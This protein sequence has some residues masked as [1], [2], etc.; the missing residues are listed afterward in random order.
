MHIHL[1]HQDNFKGEA[2]C[3]LLEGEGY[4][5]SFYQNKVIDS[6]SE[7]P[8]KSSPLLML[9]D[10]A[11]LSRLNSQQL[12]R[13]YNNQR[14]IILLGKLEHLYWLFKFNCDLT[15]F[16]SEKEK[17][18]ALNSGIN[19]VTDNKPFLSKKI[20]NFLKKDAYKQHKILLHQNLSSYFT[21]TELKTMYQIATGNTTKQIA[22]K[23][24]RSYHT[25]NN[26]RKNI[27]KKLGLKGTFRLIKF[28]L[29]QKNEIQTL[30]SLR[31]NRERVI[32]TIKNNQR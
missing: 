27:L 5:V 30:I 9:I 1:L 31:E 6:S 20:I 4:E 7:F 17:I 14:K 11:Y 13:L 24:N 18:D 26:H 23:W 32:K 28:C 22:E 19:K 29:E 12:S 15:C 10:T 25:I 21:T 8:I 16:I 2:L 3:T